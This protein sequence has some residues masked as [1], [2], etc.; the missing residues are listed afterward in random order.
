GDF[1]GVQDFIFA[2]G[3][4]TRKRAAKLLRGRSFY[5]S[6]LMECVAFHILSTLDLPVTSQVSNAAGKLLLVAPDTA[7]VRRQIP[8]LQQELDDW[9]LENTLGQYRA[10][11]TGSKC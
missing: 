3:G 2:S 6:L 10:G 8:V 11:D 7:E 1:F 9:F 4:D 5:V